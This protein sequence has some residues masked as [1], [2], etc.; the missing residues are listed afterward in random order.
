MLRR[1]LAPSVRQAEDK[2]VLGF[3][4]ICCRV[5]V[6]HKV[7]VDL[8]LAAVS[9]RSEGHP[10]PGFLEEPTRVPLSSVRTSE[11][12]R[13]RGRPL[14]FSCRSPCVGALWILYLTPVEGVSASCA[15]R[16][17]LEMSRACPGSSSTPPFL[18]DARHHE[19]KPSA[20]LRHVRGAHLTSR[21]SSSL[22]GTTPTVTSLSS[23]CRPSVKRRTKVSCVVSESSCTYITSIPE[24]HTFIWLTASP[25]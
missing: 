20:A 1:R 25:S 24:G 18:E 4:A 16:A 10:V 17:A 23:W 8:L 22:T 14:T 5:L 13:W 19:A 2:E 6:A 9:A 7:P 21:G 15:Q 11:A 12:C 3:G